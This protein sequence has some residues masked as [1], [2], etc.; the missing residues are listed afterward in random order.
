VARL[1]LV[2]GLLFVSTALA[3]Q[4]TK[5]PSDEEQGRISY[6]RHCLACHGMTNAGDGPVAD[7]LVAEVP[8]LERKM[9]RKVRERQITGVLEGVG[10]MPA[11]ATSLDSEDARKVIEYM[12]KLSESNPHTAPKI[13]PE[14]DE[15]APVKNGTTTRSAPA[16]R[17]T[18]ERSVNPNAPAEKPAVPVEKPAEPADEDQGE[19]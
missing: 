5:R 3:E 18:L 12:S 15:S 9:G 7:A 1:G 11:F 10:S 19:K 17:P 4:S 8:P 16:T 2:F 13:D 14:E 6:E